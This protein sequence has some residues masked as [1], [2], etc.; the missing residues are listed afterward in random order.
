[1]AREIREDQ[2]YRD[3]LLKLIPS[4]IVAAYLVLQ[5]IVPQHRAK[6]GMLIVSIILL[7]LTPLY[8]SMIQKVKR[9]SQLT[10][11]TISFVVW[12]YSLGGPFREW[13]LHEAWIAS[14]I[15][16]VWTLIVPLVL[17]PKQQPTIS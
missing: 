14:I 6:W 3:T 1:M 4:E 7:V 5:G 8:L 10:V 13:G 12:I 2:K 11:T 17:N 9:S 15:L 16:V